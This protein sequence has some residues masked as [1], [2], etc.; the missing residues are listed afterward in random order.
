VTAASNSYLHA[1]LQGTVN[2]CLDV[3]DMQW[4]KND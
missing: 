3:G 2:G 1:M 4:C